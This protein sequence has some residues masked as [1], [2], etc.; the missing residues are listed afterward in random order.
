MFRLK[1]PAVDTRPIPEEIPCL[2]LA[3]SSRAWTVPSYKDRRDYPPVTVARLVKAQALDN[4][5]HELRQE[6]D[7]HANSRFYKNAQGLLV[8]RA[9]L[10]RAK[11]VYVPKALRTE[12]LTL[13]HA[14]ANAGHPG[15]N[16][17]YVSMR[18]FFY[19]KSMVADVYDNAANCRTCAKGRVGGRRRTNPLRLFPATEPLSDVCLDLLG[20]L[21]KTAAGNRYILVLVDRFSTLTRV[22]PLPREDAEAVVSAFYDTWVASYGPPDTLLTDNGPQLTSTLVAIGR[23]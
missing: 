21:P 7:R 22:A 1:T 15:A 19:W 18:R 6:M 12:L 4:R 2:T 5:C 3:N 14:P 17:M 13:E 16:M 8:R 11:H 10:D 20:P 9:L 23:G